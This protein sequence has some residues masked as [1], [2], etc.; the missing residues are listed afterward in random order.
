[1]CECGCTVDVCVSVRVGSV[2][3]SV[4]VDVC[5]TCGFIE[6]GRISECVYI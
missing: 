4:G 2:C 5:G 6:K 3:V 1:M